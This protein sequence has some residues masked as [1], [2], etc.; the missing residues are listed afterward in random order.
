[1]FKS[2][3]FAVLSR[4]FVCCL[5]IAEVELQQLVP[6]IE[7]LLTGLEQ[8]CEK[9][10]LDPFDILAGVKLVDQNGESSEDRGDF[11]ALVVDAHTDVSG[12]GE[13]VLERLSLPSDAVLHHLMMAGLR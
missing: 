1:M 5:R 4:R 8:V 6:L 12:V 7:F 11:G 3:Y 10:L 9:V 13:E 2:D